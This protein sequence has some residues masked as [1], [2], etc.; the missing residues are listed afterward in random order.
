MN[1]KLL[2]ITWDV[3]WL[4][5]GTR[6]S[7]SNLNQFICYGIPLSLYVDKGSW[8]KVQS[9]SF[10]IIQNMIKRSV[11]RRA[12]VDSICDRFR[13]PFKN[14]VCK[15]KLKSKPYGFST[16]DGLDLL[17]CSKQYRSIWESTTH[18]SISISDY[19]S[20][21]RLPNFFE[22][23]SIIID[24]VLWYLGRVPTCCTC[25]PELRYGRLLC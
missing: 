6:Y 17:H 15:S 21:S 13:I 4:N 7:F 14:H 12:R 2:H 1:N 11:A 19:Y 16:C 24:F 25:G 5:M 20:N 10:S 8:Y 23:S 22:Q 3:I 9:Q 18:P